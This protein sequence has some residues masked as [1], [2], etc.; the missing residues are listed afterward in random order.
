MSAYYK[1]TDNISKRSR[2][3]VVAVPVVLLPLSGIIILL[4]ITFAILR[5][6]IIG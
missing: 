6:T 4:G 1:H 2:V 5:L 3:R